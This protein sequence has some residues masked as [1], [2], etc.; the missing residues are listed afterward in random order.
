MTEQEANIHGHRFTVHGPYVPF[1]RVCRR[2][3][4]HPTE[5]GLKSVCV[6][7]YDLEDLDDE[8]IVTH[9]VKLFEAMGPPE[10]TE[11]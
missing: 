7:L 1:D 2:V 9:A 5:R 4:G 10:E 3:I 11:E 6:D 8:E